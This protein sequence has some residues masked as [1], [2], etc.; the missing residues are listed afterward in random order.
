MTR[1]A[2]FQNKL[3]QANTLLSVKDQTI[4]RLQKSYDNARTLAHKFEKE[5]LDEIK[6]KREA[7]FEAFVGKYCRTYNITGGDVD[8]TKRE[9]GTL[10]EA[11]LDR[12]SADLEKVSARSIS[13]E[14]IVNSEM[15]SPS[16]T[17]HS[18][19]EDTPHS[20]IDKTSQLFAKVQQLKQSNR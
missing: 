4:A 7:K 13:M 5:K 20:V 11:A 2:T 15:M 3:T 19:D 12:I 1:T 6:A 14:P 18:K 9:L 8:I 16:E 10:S 17:A